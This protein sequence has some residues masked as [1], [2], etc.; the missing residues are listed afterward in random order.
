MAS[1]DGSSARRS[2]DAMQ[3]LGKR[4]S[5]T[6]FEHVSSQPDLLRIGRRCVV[7]TSRFSFDSFE[8]LAHFPL[9]LIGKEDVARGGG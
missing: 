6:R 7:V 3:F 5:R 2:R 4:R 1:A 8:N 9:F